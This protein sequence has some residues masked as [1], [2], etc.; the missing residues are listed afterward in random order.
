MEKDLSNCCPTCGRKY[1]GVKTFDG[2]VASLF[3]AILKTAGDKKVKWINPR[4]AFD[5]T[6]RERQ[7]IV[8]NCVTSKELQKTLRSTQYARIGDLKYW[9]LLSQR[10]E[11]W[12]QGIYQITGLARLFA[13]GA[14]SVPKN[15]IVAKGRRTAA[16]AEQVS[17]QAAFGSKWSDIE[18]WINDWNKNNPPP[19]QEEQSLLL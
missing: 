19:K 6:E 15:I 16:S 13:A 8:P 14:V 12:H 7:E 5:G 18:D 4:W 17:F 3:L 11:W 9:G 1:S 2:F 10:S